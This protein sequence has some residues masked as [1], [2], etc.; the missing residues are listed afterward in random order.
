MERPISFLKLPRE[1]I[2]VLVNNWL[3]WENVSRWDCAN[4]NREHR[5]EW[6]DILKTNSLTKSIF[7]SFDRSDTFSKEQWFVARCI[8]ARE[9]RSEVG[10]DFNDAVTMRWMENTGPTLERVSIRDVRRVQVLENIVS[11]C[12]KLK[13]FTCYS[14]KMNDRHLK[15]ISKISNLEELNLHGN[16]NVPTDLVFPSL[17]KLTISWELHSRTN[18][19]ML[20]QQLPALRSL[21]LTHYYLS[22][23][24][25][26]VAEAWAYIVHLDLEDSGRCGTYENEGEEFVQLMRSLRTSLRCLILPKMMYYTSR[27]L[28]S[29]VDCHGQSLRCIST[30]NYVVTGHFPAVVD[31][32]NNLP[33]LNTLVISYRALPHLISPV[34]NRNITHLYAEMDRASLSFLGEALAKHFPSLTTLSI[35]ATYTYNVSEVVDVLTLRPSVHTVFVIREGNVATELRKLMPKVTVKEGPGFD[36]FRTDY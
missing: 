19:S 33:L 12:N 13:A 4:C 28:Q 20:I 17:C 16:F 21:R 2:S 15:C 10:E 8:R 26:D 29:I 34:V 31:L 5:S 18:A 25:S 22:D 6:L 32:L 14:C 27:D 23:I 1:L 35:S 24:C 30:P 11:V 3:T 7:L 9:L 36:M